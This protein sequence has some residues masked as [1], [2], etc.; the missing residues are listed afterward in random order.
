M[1]SMTGVNCGA[2]QGGRGFPCTPADIGG[3][4]LILVE[5]LPLDTTLRV[6][7]LWQIHFLQSDRP[8]FCLPVPRVR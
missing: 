7:A 2:G 4:D 5:T 8:C 1:T 6:P 3:I